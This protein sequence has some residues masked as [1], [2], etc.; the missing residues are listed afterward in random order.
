MTKSLGEVVKVDEKVWGK[1]VEDINECFEPIAEWWSST[2]LFMA[3]RA[4]TITEAEA[5]WAESSGRHPTTERE[6][7]QAFMNY[8]LEKNDV[9][10]DHKAE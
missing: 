10:Q 5:R 8:I 7:R 4:K 6:K 1:F 2:L 9:A 3:R